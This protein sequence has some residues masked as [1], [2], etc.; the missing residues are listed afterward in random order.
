MVSPAY[1]G[2]LPRALSL[3]SHLGTMRAQSWLYKLWQ[4]QAAPTASV[5]SATLSWP[6]L[7]ALSSDLDVWPLS[8]NPSKEENLPDTGWSESESQNHPHV[9]ENLRTPARLWVKVT[10]IE[11]Y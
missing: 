6:E 5:L 7:C 8:R 4:E 1:L 11:N 10:T 2:N 9:S 3:Q